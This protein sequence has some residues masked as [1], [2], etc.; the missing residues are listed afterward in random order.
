MDAKPRTAVNRVL[1]ALAASRQ[2]ELSF[3]L[4]ALALAPWVEASLALVGLAKTLDALDG[5]ISPQAPANPLMGSEAER[6]VARALR[7]QPWLPGTCLSRAV[8]QYALHRRDGAAVT[9]VVGVRRS[10]AARVEAHAWVEPPVDDASDY[11][12]I[13]RRSTR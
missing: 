10:A 9:L 2:D 5:L 6:A 1:R 4:R 8:V 12:P 11:E 3:A 7:V 13:L